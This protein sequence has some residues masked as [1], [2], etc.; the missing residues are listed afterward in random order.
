MIVEAPPYLLESIPV[1]AD[2]F[3]ARE[4]VRV[5]L[6]IQ[7]NGKEVEDYSKYTIRGS[8]SNVAVV[9][10]NQEGE[11]EANTAED[12]DVRI[13]SDGQHH[14]ITVRKVREGIMYLHLKYDGSI[15]KSLPF[16]VVSWQESLRP[17]IIFFDGKQLTDTVEIC[18][19]QGDA[20]AESKTNTTVWAFLR[21]MYNRILEPNAEKSGG[22]RIEEKAGNTS[23]GALKPTIKTG[24]IGTPITIDAAN[25]PGGNYRF[26]VKFYPDADNQR[27]YQSK[28]LMVRVVKPEV[29]LKANDDYIYTQEKGDAK[30]AAEAF[31]VYL[32]GVRVPLKDNDFSEPAPDAY[33][34]I[35]KVQMSESSSDAEKFQSITYCIKYKIGEEDGGK[36]IYETIDCTFSGNELP[37]INPQLSESKDL[38]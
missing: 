23:S 17:N 13:E 19:Y 29:T 37:M 38:E 11:N 22:F 6:K 12:N 16:S 18:N 28:D 4:A 15:L 14:Y 21:D 10:Q 27:Y 25:S 3:F 34:T 1:P 33:Y 30:N 7:K 8:N 26:T 35:T 20:R 31:N 2:L 5:Y 32:N 9:V 24:G 36:A